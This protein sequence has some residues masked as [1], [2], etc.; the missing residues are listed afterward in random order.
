MEFRSDEFHV[1]SFQHAAFGQF[2]GDI[3]SCLTSQSGKQRLRPLL[4]DNPLNYIR[5]NRLH[6]CS[7][8]HLRI[9]HDGC[10]IAVHQNDL[11]TF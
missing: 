5:N 10:G 11:I 3:K 6:V 4:S 9:G 7:V 1:I 2:H 8:S